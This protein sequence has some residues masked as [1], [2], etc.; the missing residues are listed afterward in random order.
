MKADCKVFKDR[1]NYWEPDIVLQGE[2]NGEYFEFDLSGLESGFY[3]TNQGVFELV[4]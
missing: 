4:D 2:Q 3:L 1:E